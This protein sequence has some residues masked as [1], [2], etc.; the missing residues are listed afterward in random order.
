MRQVE[1][2]PNPYLK[3]SSEFLCEP[4]ATRLEVFEETATRSMITKSF[5]PDMG[6]RWTVNCY[7]G[8]IHACTYCFARRY[9]EFLGYGA[10]TDFETKIVAK[11]NA[12]EVLRAD[13]KKTKEKIPFLEFSFATDPYLPLEASYELTRKCLM[14]CRDFRMPVGIVTKSPLVTRDLDILKDLKCTV[15]F[16]I[17][18]PTTE[19]SKPF[20][21]YTPIPDVRFRAM[22]TLADAGIKVGIGIAPIIL[23]YNDSDIPVLLEKAKAAG[24]TKAFLNLIHIDSDSIEEYFV[25]KLHEKLPNQAAKIINQ[26][27]RERGGELRHKTFADRAGKTEKWNMAV[28][29]FEMHFRRLGFERFERIEK[30][31]EKAL[32]V[33]RKLF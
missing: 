8:C 28:K 6:D 33:Q 25:Q 23:G 14:V 16:S 1:N 9:H 30:R 7:R 13:L 24:A 27:K 17:P 18:F 4:P 19:K 26:Q 2:P 31:E 21:L 11:I 32:P 29:L 15:F 22:K 12:P 10:G 20:E 3:Y 5:M